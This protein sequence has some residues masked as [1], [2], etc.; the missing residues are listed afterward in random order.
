MRSRSIRVFAWPRRVTGV[1]SG[2]V[3]RRLLT[4]RSAARAKTSDEQDDKNASLLDSNR[5]HCFQKKPFMPANG[6]NKSV[7]ATNQLCEDVTSFTH[8]AH[9]NTPFHATARCQWRWKPS[10]FPQPE[11]RGDLGVGRQA[12][13]STW[14]HFGQ[15]R[16]RRR[17]AK[18][19]L[20]LH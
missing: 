16:Y 10:I 9:G 19:L 12:H 4:M 2:I 18:V 5:N 7:G 14:T 20:L 6:R 15:T 13:V 3:R 1:L 8:V 17:I 11:W